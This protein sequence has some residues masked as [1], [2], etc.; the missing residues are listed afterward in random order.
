[1][2]ISNSS[3]FSC[4][5]GDTN[6][7]SQTR[8][9]FFFFLYFQHAPQCYRFDG[10]TIRNQTW[11]RNK[12]KIYKKEFPLK[13]IDRIV[14]KIGV[15]VSGSKRQKVSIFVMQTIESETHKIIARVVLFS[16]VDICMHINKCQQ[17]ALFPDYLVT[18][19]KLI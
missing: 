19:N 6:I 2:S 7:S 14:H 11:I 15:V 10:G 3:R 8:I 13:S 17:L 9:L 4:L 12:L 5:T 1:M 16:R 18:L